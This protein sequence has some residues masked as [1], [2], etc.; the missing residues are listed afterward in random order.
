VKPELPENIDLKIIYYQKTKDG[1]E[2]DYGEV[3]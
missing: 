3:L 2:V 1:I